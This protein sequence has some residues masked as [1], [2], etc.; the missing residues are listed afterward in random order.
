MDSSGGGGRSYYHRGGGRRGGR[1]RGRGGGGGRGRGAYRHQPYGRGNN[2][3][4]NNRN[5]RPGNR[6]GG[7]Q[8][9]AQD[10]ETAMIRQV[11]S[12]VSRVGEFKNIREETII[13]PDG[14]ETITTA[15]SL[16]PLEAT[17]A[18]NINDLVTVLCSEDKMEMLFRYHII[19][20][21]PELKT[22]SESSMSVFPIAPEA[23]VGKLGHVLIS[24]AAGLPLQ[25]PCYAAL[26][27]A[28]HERIKATPWPGFAH[29]C[30]EYAMHHISKDLDDALSSG[31][32]IAQEACRIKLLLRFIAILGKI[33][34]VQ[35]FQNEQAMNPN[36]L[37]VFGLLSL[38]VEA[39]KAAQQRNAATVSYL[40]ATLVLSTIPYIMEYVPQESI[41]EWILKPIQTLM[42][43]YK[44]S[45]TPGTGPSAILLKAEQDDGDGNNDDEEE[46]EDEEDDDTSSQ[47]CDSLQ[48]LLRVVGK[49]Q[50]P[51]RFRLPVDS[52]WKGL[53]QVATPNPESGET[54]TTLVTY[55]GE[56][57][58][59]SVGNFR[60]LKLLLGG[61]G[62]FQLVPFDLDG[63]VF[64]RLPI[65]GP[66]PSPDEE[67]EE[68]TED[69]L[70]PNENLQ[71]FKT[72]FGLVDRFFVSETLRDCL[73]SHESSV[74]P[75]GL[76]HGSPKSVAE[77]VMSLHHL[78]VGENSA[79]G[80]EYAMVETIFGLVAQSREQCAL[81]HTTVSRILLELTRLQP[82]VFSPSLAVA[83][84]NL[85]EDYLPALVP[86]ARD[87]FS[88]WFSFHLI[89]TDYQWPSAYWNLWEPYALSPNKSSRGDFV[90]RAL[91]LM[92]ENVSDP[93]VLVRE[94]L[95]GSSSLTKE[96][97]P[98][99]T[100]THVDHAEGSAL[101]SLETEIERRVWDEHEDPGLLSEFLLGEEVANA[102]QDGGGIWLRS[103]I[104]T[105]VLVSPFIKIHRNLKDMLDNTEKND[106][107]MVDDMALS[108]DFFLIDSQDDR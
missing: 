7:D 6:F 73:I 54:E 82:Q 62:D 29:R 59:L 97:F 21:S 84:T 32:N 60:S 103:Q 49:M 17:T 26:T 75:T 86:Q 99:T 19:E 27:L 16:R 52:P 20:D 33:G 64:G 9:A 14:D 24:C 70:P 96:F 95:S 15:I 43:E 2:N 65:F 68:E 28:I 102:L 87:N 71:A 100:A 55:T 12:F 39:A 44:S 101:A 57:I 31:K 40:L 69:S 90:Q 67:E 30:V 42:G 88:Q 23:K 41:V 18:A 74:N 89:N 66:P 8:V 50:E 85:F 72:G 76:Q 13:T 11:S 47:V 63:V 45:F 77:E 78:F 3:S 53:T 25:T 48:D 106:D 46:D 34:V 92:V 1:G 107:D 91:Q 22:D 35:G 51:S 36:Q 94:C 10:P 4:N 58:Y 81:K 98:R 79:K 56:S 93:S 83:M 61:E 38:L 104:L 80:L 108:K 37:T 105:R 5:R